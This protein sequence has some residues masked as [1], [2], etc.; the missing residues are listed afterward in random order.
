MKLNYSKDLQC[1]RADIFKGLNSLLMLV[2]IRDGKKGVQDLFTKLQ[3][4]VKLPMK[5]K[6]AEA[7]MELTCNGNI[8]PLFRI[9]QDISAIGEMSSMYVDVF[10]TLLK[11]FSKDTADNDEPETI[12]LNLLRDL[13]ISQGK[14][15]TLES[16]GYMK[17]VSIISSTIIPGMIAVVPNSGTSTARARY[18]QAAQFIGSRLMYQIRV[19]DLTPDEEEKF[20]TESNSL[21]NVCGVSALHSFRNMLPQFMLPKLPTNISSESSRPMPVVD[22]VANK[23]VEDSEIMELSRLQP[24]ELKQMLRQRNLPDYGAR[25]ALVSRLQEDVRK[26]KQESVVEDSPKRSRKRR[27]SRVDEDPRNQTKSSTVTRK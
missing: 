23:G 6:V 27:N 12:L 1:Y 21:V 20:W 9:L 19:L 18:P 4:A 8:M 11:F 16:H 14:M 24:K 10:I 15:S 17:V 13:N 22:M 2:A 5:A 7:D 26:R 3:S 25:P